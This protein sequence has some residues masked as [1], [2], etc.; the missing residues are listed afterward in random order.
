MVTTDG[1]DLAIYT[2]MLAEAREALVR[3]ADRVQALSE[4]VERLDAAERST[5]VRA[6]VADLAYLAA[7]DEATKAD[8]EALM[9]RLAD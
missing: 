5:G 3:R 8:H 4:L 2:A 1:D 6:T 9:R 7:R